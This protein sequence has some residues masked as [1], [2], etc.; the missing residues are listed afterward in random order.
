ME[1]MKEKLV[2]HA[3]PRKWIIFVCTFPFF[4]Q[5]A[6]TSER[7]FMLSKFSNCMYRSRVVSHSYRSTSLIALT[8]EGARCTFAVAY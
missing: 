4:F 1:V 7:Y 2:K 6:L 3:K 8:I 5:E